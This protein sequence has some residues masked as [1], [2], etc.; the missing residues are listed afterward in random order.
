MQ[1]IIFLCL[2]HNDNMNV[3]IVPILRKLRAV[4]KFFALNFVKQL[5]LIIDPKYLNKN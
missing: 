4:L 3:M 2:L 5:Y 1:Y